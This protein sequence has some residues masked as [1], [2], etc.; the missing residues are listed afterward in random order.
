MC[1]P[2]FLQGPTQAKGEKKWKCT[3]G[4]LYFCD[5]KL[6]IMGDVRAGV[7]HKFGTHRNTLYCTYWC[8]NEYD[9]NTKDKLCY[10]GLTPDL[11]LLQSFAM[12]N[13]S[14]P[15]L[16]ILLLRAPVEQRNKFWHEKKQIRKSWIVLPEFLL[17]L[18]QTPIAFPLLLLVRHRVDPSGR[19][20]LVL[21]SGSQLENCTTL[22]TWRN[23]S[24]NS[25]CCCFCCCCC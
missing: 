17:D 11:A 18:P 23:R 15:V 6:T 13:A 14:P 5:K 9:N 1:G 21:P 4:Q 24:W 12:R 25:R 22:E 8:T 16:F 2:F 7:A 19:G 20:S 10:R 3:F